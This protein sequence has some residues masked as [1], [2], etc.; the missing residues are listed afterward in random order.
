M[1]FRIWIRVHLFRRFLLCYKNKKKFSTDYKKLKF[2]GFRQSEFLKNMFRNIYLQK[3]N[4]INQCQ[5]LA[6]FFIF[7][8]RKKKKKIGNLNIINKLINLKYKS[9]R[10]SNNN[11]KNN[12]DY[13]MTTL[14]GKTIILEGTVLKIAKKIETITTLLIECEKC[15]S[16][17][18]FIFDILNQF[19]PF[20]CN[21]SNCSSKKFFSH[22]SRVFTE[23]I[24]KIK[25]GRIAIDFKK[26]KTS[27][28]VILNIHGNKK[29]PIFLGSNI[30][31]RALIKL[32]PVSKTFSSILNK[33]HLYSLF[34]QSQNFKI[35]SY[36]RIGFKDNF[37]I[38]KKDLLFIN[39]IIS[40]TDIFHLLIK[41]IQPELF[42]NEG[43]K[44]CIILLASQNLNISSN[45]FRHNILN[46]CMVLSNLPVS[47]NFF[48]KELIKSFP[49]SFFLTF[50]S[51]KYKINRNTK[52]KLFNSWKTESEFRNSILFIECNKNR[53]KNFK[54]ETLLYKIKEI[55]EKK[56]SMLSHCIIIL[57]VYIDRMCIQK[58]KNIHGYF[59]NNVSIKNSFDLSY[60]VKNN[61]VETVEKFKTSQFLNFQNYKN[62]KINFRRF[63]KTKS[64]L[65]T[66][67]LHPLI[68]KKKVSAYFLKKYL[69]FIQSFPESNLS[70]KSL[71]IL[72]D[73]YK[74]LRSTNVTFLNFSFNFLFI[75]IKLV[76]CRAKIDLR[77]QTCPDDIYD[78][79]EIILDSKPKFLTTL[80]A[81]F[82][83]KTTK[84]NTK[85]A[86][87]YKFM[88]LLQK[89][90]FR[91]G[92]TLF[93][94][95]EF[96]KTFQN[97]MSFS[98]ILEIF[99]KFKIINKIKKNLF[100][101][102][103]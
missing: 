82:K 55:L 86:L 61:S 60:V 65:R 2:G 11:K 103:I 93:E 69:K 91:T 7:I 21:K 48:F 62:N 99:K 95:E 47:D 102:N 9:L 53:Q 84:I 100:S 16:L 34:M 18:Y 17:F 44:A 10:S 52:N 24:Q 8:I 90:F 13:F 54:P 40:T 87:F 25:L 76:Q 80:I 88:R 50:N 41:N 32:V 42:G 1:S 29:I 5:S 59:S 64:S 81:N 6:K 75:L 68:I 46:F 78:G 101:L 71:N 89:F 39:R 63:I 92:Q 97:N 31:C 14:I 23:K 4:E 30:F 83:Y 35:S 22:F 70:I 38:S 79:L 45:F 37:F 49:K 94:T 57:V 67:I 98:E 43:L 12:T 28:L 15:T 20:L 27:E 96:E 56:K 74:R 66:S 58:E 51:F 85:I 26:S 36:N 19:L 33:K 77:E 72:L 3:I 73:I